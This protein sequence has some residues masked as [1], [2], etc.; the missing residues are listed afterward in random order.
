V[1]AA[2]EELDLAIAVLR[3]G[4]VAAGFGH[5]GAEIEEASAI[6][7]GHGVL[8]AAGCDE[9]AHGPDFEFIERD[10]GEEAVALK[11]LPSAALRSRPWR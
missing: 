3:G 11:L 4:E 10:G 6:G 5:G 9:S 7:A 8:R 2:A 1:I